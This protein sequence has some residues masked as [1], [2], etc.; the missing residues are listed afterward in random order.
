MDIFKKSVLDMEFEQW[1]I[2][3]KKHGLGHHTLKVQWTG[4]EMRKVASFLS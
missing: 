1:Q 2:K 3:I 4:W